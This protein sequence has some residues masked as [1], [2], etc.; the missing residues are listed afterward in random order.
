VVVL[1]LGGLLSVAV[2]LWV[3]EKFVIRRVERLIRLVRNIDGEGGLSAR[4]RVRG[5]D[6]FAQLGLHLNAMLERL[7]NSQDKIAAAQERLRFEATH[8][9]LTGIWNRGAALRL[10]DA[11]LDR[12]SRDGTSVAV[13]LFDADHFKRINDSFGHATGDRTL[14]SVAAAITSS[15]RSSDVCCR[16]GGEEFLVIAPNCN[17]EQ[18]VQLARR[19]LQCCCAT[20]VTLPDQAFCVTLSAGVTATTWRCSG[21]D[22]ILV[23]DR[24]LYRA[25]EAGRNRVEA[26]DVPSRQSIRSV[27]FAPDE[28]AAPVTDEL[29]PKTA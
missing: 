4:I 25:K 2:T 3:M 24:A 23:A 18:G 15:L 26:E 28:L 12:A 9:A 29:P 22:L 10:L 14:Q 16:Y 8:D 21:D 13:I 20:P 17:L 7:Q 6:E 19:V 5:S 11:E 1:V 27:R